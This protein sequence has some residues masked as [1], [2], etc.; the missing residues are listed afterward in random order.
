MAEFTDPADGH[1]FIGGS[2]HTPSTTTR[3]G[4]VSPATEEVYA[5]IARPASTEADHAVDEARTA[6]D[7]GAW[8]SMPVDARAEVIERACDGVE[9]R[10]AEIAVTCAYE[11]GAPISQT[12][13][14]VMGAALVVRQMCDSARSMPD[15]RIGVGQWHYEVQYEPI[16]VVLNIVPWNSPFAG[17]MRHTA[18]ALLAGCSVI[19]KPSPDTPFSAVI[20]GRVLQAAGLPDGT[21]SAVPAEADVSEYLVCHGAVDHVAFI[22]GTPTGRR[23]AEL[24]G[25]NLKRYVLEL[26]GKSAAIVLDDADVARAAKAVAGGVFHNSGQICSA[27]TRVVVPPAL[28]AE[29]VEALLLEASARSLGDPLDEQ[30]TMGPLA[31]SAHQ[32]RVLAAIRQ[33]QEEGAELQFGGR[34]PAEL[35]RGFFVEPTVF[36]GHNDMRLA[37]DEIFG[38]VA[39]V[40]PHDGDDDA[41]RIANDSQFGLGGA[42]FS[43]DQERAV[44]IASRIQTGSV[45]INAYTTNMLAPRDPQKDSGWGTSSGPEGYQS[46]ARS[47][48]VNLRPA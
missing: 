13:Q 11:I 45:S 29:M 42:V 48:T 28:V 22:G 7:S 18:Q 3:V 19:A 39:V 32:Q 4:L 14:S 21:Y 5:E 37:R 47:R 12:R 15:S 24:C 43:A 41:V 17:M 36:V 26:G 9:Q 34:R 27:L 23:V 6:F 10:A 33:G 2:L 20:W 35:A 8:S 30:T 25:R 38:P 31:S 16:G 1:F 46:Y 40:I 44:A